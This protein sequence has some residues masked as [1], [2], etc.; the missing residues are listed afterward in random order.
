[1]AL[2]EIV[3]DHMRLDYEGL[4]D[5]RELHHMIDYYF[6]EKGYDKRETKNYEKVTPEGRYIELELTPWKKTTDYIRNIIKVR[7]IMSSVKDVEIEKDNT[8]IKLQRGRVQ[9]VIDGFFDYDYDNRWDYNPVHVFI[10]TIFDKYFFK[11]YWDKYKGVLIED[12]NMLHNMIKNYFNLF[13]AY[14]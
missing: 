10:R 5:A 9:F 14:R 2:R 4:F 7:L 8:K 12:T 6:R 3:I 13:K 1:M 11:T